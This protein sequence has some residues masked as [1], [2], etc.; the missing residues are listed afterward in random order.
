MKDPMAA[1]PTGRMTSNSPACPVCRST[2]TD[3]FADARDRLFGLAQG[4]FRLYRC[5]FCECVFQHPLPDALA[6]ASFYPEE[7]WWASDSSDAR[8]ARLM[9]LERAYREFVASDHVR[10]LEQCAAGTPGRSLLDIG[11]GNGLFLH[12]AH[13]RGFLPHGMDVSARAA[14][15]ARKQHDLQ[16][17][18][19]EIGAPVWEGYSFDFI[20]MFHVLEHLT[21]PAGALAY[22]G[23]LLKPGGS[24]I[25]QV[26]NVSSFQSRLF[27]TRWYGLDVPRHIIN[28][29]PRSLGL[30]LDRA[31][32]RYGLMQRFSL[33][34]NPAALAS[35]VAIGLDPIGRRGRGKRTGALAEA[36]LEFS[37]FGLT[38]LAFLPTWIESALGHSATMWVHARKA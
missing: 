7:Y 17:R 36:A 15:E 13:K 12:L 37:Y 35:S 3:W 8:P 26:P 1:G 11:C 20:T 29:A 27:R 16:V 31:G 19:G 33:R 28:F 24:L 25:L 38:C 14:A 10:F 18:V 9:R 5:S 22:A 23:G 21:D 30:L 2:A 32:F 34:D 4:R 6:I